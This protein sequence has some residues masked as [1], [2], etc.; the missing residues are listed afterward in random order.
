MSGIPT[1]E[2]ERLILR[3][4]NL[5]DAADVMR[6]AGDRD[7]ADTTLNIPHPYEPG[8][9]EQWISM[10]GEDFDQGRGVTLALAL[11][12]DGRLVGAISLNG[13]GRQPSGGDGILGRQA[14]LGPG[15][16]H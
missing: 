2:T 5:N 7:I 6:L 10:H 16:L 11:R 13:N 15:I 14:V 8:M 4:F 9:A 3:P 12:E 1:I